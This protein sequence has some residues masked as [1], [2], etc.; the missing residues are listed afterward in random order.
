MNKPLTQC[1]NFILFFYTFNK[2]ISFSYKIKL[3]RLVLES[4][5]NQFCLL[6]FCLCP[7][8]IKLSVSYL[9][10]HVFVPFFL[11]SFVAVCIKY[12]LLGSKLHKSCF[13]QKHTFQPLI[14]ENKRFGNSQKTFLELMKPSFTEAIKIQTKNKI[15]KFEKL[16]NYR[17]ILCRA[18]VVTSNQNHQIIPT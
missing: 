11:S 15:M 10:I 8:C 18:F 17:C 14:L 3:P 16:Q 6:L 2:I 1:H 4:G 7:F 9:S 13:Q 12:V 5:L